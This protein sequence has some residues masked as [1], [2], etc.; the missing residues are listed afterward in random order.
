MIY[1]SGRKIPKRYTNLSDPSETDK[2]VDIQSTIEKSRNPQSVSPLVSNNAASAGLRSNEQIPIQIPLSILPLDDLK[3]KATQARKDA[4]RYNVY[5]SNANRDK[6]QA[7]AEKNIYANWEAVWQKANTSGVQSL[8]A[9]EQNIWE[10]FNRLY[11]TDAQKRNLLDSFYATLDQRIAGNEKVINQ[12]LRLNQSAKSV[13]QSYQEK[14][15]GSSVNRN[16][17]LLNYAGEDATQSLNQPNTSNNDINAK[18]MNNQ[19]EKTASIKKPV[20]DNEEFHSVLEGLTPAQAREFLIKEGMP[21]EMAMRVQSE[22]DISKLMSIERDV[23]GSKKVE[24]GATLVEPQFCKADT[25]IMNWIDY[26]IQLAANSNDKRYSKR[27]ASLSEEFFS[28][29]TARKNSRHNR[30]VIDGLYNYSNWPDEQGIAIEYLHDDDLWKNGGKGTFTQEI[31]SA[32]MEISI[33]KLMKIPDKIPTSSAILKTIIHAFAVDTYKEY[34]P[35]F[36]LQEGDIMVYD[37]LGGKSFYRGNELLYTDFGGGYIKFGPHYDEYIPSQEIR[38]M[39]AIESL[40]RDF[41]LARNL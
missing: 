18:L 28:E 22:Q 4:D 30:K 17:K 33:L 2:D 32:I 5:L 6:Q 40:I 10:P 21:L 1:M 29:A 35:G 37:G 19:P 20:T 34:N 31:A 24:S 3:W 25:A 8:A 7:Q 36:V 15:E 38:N 9:E 39:E 12:G 14:L 11:R 41:V 26:Q 23:W 16:K 13:E 27:L